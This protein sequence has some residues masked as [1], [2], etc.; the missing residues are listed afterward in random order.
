MKPKLTLVE[1]NTQ[2]FKCLTIISIFLFLSLSLS[3]SLLKFGWDILATKI[4]PKRLLLRFA[5]YAWKFCKSYSFSE[6]LPSISAFHLMWKKTIS[7]DKPSI[8]YRIL[9]Q[10]IFH[11]QEK[12]YR[13]SRLTFSAS[14]VVYLW[15]QCLKL[16]SIHFYCVCAIDLF[17]KAKSL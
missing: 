15:K 1:I 6:G 10:N 13:I 5:M 7:N 17:L 16:P 2:M 3:P 9:T 4:F 8:E 11:E 12:H 14:L